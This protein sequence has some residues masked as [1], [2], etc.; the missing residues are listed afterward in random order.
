MGVSA[1]CVFTDVRLCVDCFGCFSSVEMTSKHARPV[2]ELA[3]KPAASSN[4]TIPFHYAL[5]G[6]KRSDSAV[7]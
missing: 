6:N 5:K 7:W 1:S 4:Q 3:Q 2:K